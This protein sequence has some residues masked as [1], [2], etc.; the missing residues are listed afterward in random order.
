MIELVDVT[1]VIPDPDGDR[2]ML[3]AQSARFERHEKVGILAAAGS[4]KSSLARLLCG[5]ETPD[6]GQVLARG[7]V[8]WPMAYAGTLHP[9]L[10]GVQN[11]GLIADLIGDDP[12]TMLAFCGEFAG[13]SVPLHRKLKYFAPA[14]RLA[15]SFT[16]SVAVACDHYVVDEVIGYGDGDVRMRCGAMLD[17]RLQAGA[18]LIYISRNAAQLKKICTRF[19][20]MTQGQLIACPNADVAAAAL[21]L[22]NP[23]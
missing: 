18:G 6:S 17:V 16:L 15:L 3:N 13:P 21:E 19:L 22:T 20:I 7:R 2:V 14:E 8:G 4:G 5:I 10:T 23:P 9:E 1:W 12:P 11:I